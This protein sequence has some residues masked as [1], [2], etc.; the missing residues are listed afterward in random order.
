MIHLGFE[1]AAMKYGTS[2]KRDLGR[3]GPLAAVAAAAVLATACGGSTS[4]SASAPT[5]AQVLSLAQCMRSHG[6]PDFPDPNSSGSYSLTSTGELEG[7]NGSSININSTE[8]QSAYADCRHLL[9]GGPSISRLEQMEQEE[10][11][12]QAKALPGL[13]KFQQCVRSDGEPNFSLGL[14]G[15]SPAAS[16]GSV[17]PNSPQLQA[18]LRACQHLLPAGAHLSFHS[19][20]SK[21]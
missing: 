17:N 15:Q 20:S 18:A 7:A 6:E 2:G 12:A 21:S 3:A 1:E 19:S 16:K 4:S 14:G 5:Y 9:P 8:A 11:Q 13:L 10:Q